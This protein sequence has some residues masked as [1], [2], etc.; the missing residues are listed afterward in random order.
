MIK[1]NA[2]G[3]WHSF[4]NPKAPEPAWFI[5]HNW[6]IEE[7]EKVINHLK[8]GQIIRSWM[9]FSWCRFRCK[10][11]GLGAADL[12]DGTYI[13]PE[14]LSHYLENHGVRLPQEFVEHVLNYTATILDVKENETAFEY[15]A[16]WWLAQKG[17]NHN[18]SSFKSSLDIGILKIRQIDSK[19]LADQEKFIRSYL[20][21]AYGI[22]GKY[23]AI[24]QI[25][26]GKEVTIKGRFNG[27][28]KFIIGSRKYGIEVGFR[29]LTDEEYKLE[30]N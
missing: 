17:W 18:Q 14:G 23:E 16:E 8:N 9:G 6:S 7:K 15:D 5:D 11:D 29:E 2:I 28:E 26:K 22:T 4:E 20:N 21:T 3:Y 12:T 1:L 27:V 13:W 19:K 25:L 24:D 10:N 30:Y